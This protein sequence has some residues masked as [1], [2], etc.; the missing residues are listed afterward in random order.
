MAKEHFT[1]QSTIG[2]RLM[3]GLDLNSNAR[4]AFSDAYIRKLK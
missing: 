4:M 1:P 2:E 3:M